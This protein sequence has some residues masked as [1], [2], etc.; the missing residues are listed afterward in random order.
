MSASIEP[1]RERAPAKVN[2]LLHVG[3]RRA[4]GLHELCSLFASID[5]ADEV[6]VSASASGEDVVVCSGVEGPNICIAAL[7]A[8]RAAVE[9]E[10]GAA[11]GGEGAAAGGEGVPAGE[12][13]TAAGSALPPLSV[14][15]H[16]RIPVAAGLGGG[17]A[18]AGAVL[19]AANEIA[20]RP[21]GRAALR[22][23]GASVGAD[24]PSQVE[25]RHA[26]VQA[27]GER[28]EPLELPG[29][30]LVLVPQEEGLVTADVYREADRLGAT[31]SRLEPATVRR[32]AASS[33]ATLAA[34]LE[35]D[36]QAAALSLRPELAEPLERLGRAGARAVLVTGSGPTVFG[37]FEDARSARRAAPGIPASI[38]AALE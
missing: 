13:R 23:V 9:R 2:L 8:L 10:K 33:L 30:W 34:S 36:L 17:S 1:I 14:T 11:A 28:V 26:L 32:L 24:V 38:V 25:P 31:R 29:M 20:G 16:K 21:L 6:V 37:V 3:P 12:E 15:I 18:D 19:R 7:A 4:D 35:N 5:L 27:A 22:E